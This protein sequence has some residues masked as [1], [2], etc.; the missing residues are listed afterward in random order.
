MFLNEK[1]IRKLEKQYV[2]GLQQ[3]YET[4]AGKDFFKYLKFKYI[5]GTCFAETDTKTLVRLAEKELVEEIYRHATGQSI[6]DPLE[7]ITNDRS[8]N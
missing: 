7:N 8:S 3:F 4:Q 2:V 1:E 6:I 5:N